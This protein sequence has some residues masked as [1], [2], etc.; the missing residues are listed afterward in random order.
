[1]L[2]LR[3]DCAVSG[4]SRLYQTPPLG[5]PGQADYLNAVIRIHTNLDPL[6]LLGVLQAI[7]SAH[8]RERRERW[9]ARTL[10]LDI[11]DIDGCPLCHERLVLPHPELPKR[12]FVLQPLY[13][14]APKWR[15]PV[16]GA[17]VTEMIQALL[18]EGEK[19][20]LEG[21]CW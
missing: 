20:L 11:L 16:S 15:H 4:Q 3:Q 6:M 19:A 7:E 18:D 17:F 8:G 12:M 1:M 14:L 5:P 13:D 10:D 21:E 2:A 9:G